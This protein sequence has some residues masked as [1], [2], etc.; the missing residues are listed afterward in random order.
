M[1]HLYTC[2]THCNQTLE[3][4]N[5]I[6]VRLSC[7]TATTLILLSVYLTTVNIFHLL[8]CT[9]HWFSPYNVDI[10]I[11][12]APINPPFLH[13]MLSIVV[14]LLLR[15]SRKCKSHVFVDLTRSGPLHR[16]LV[17]D[18]TGLVVSVKIP[19]CLLTTFGRHLI[20]CFPTF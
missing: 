4:L 18:E 9:Q 2:S 11:E 3:P 1:Y 14:T 8:Y 15:K 6:R 17:S 19:F 7:H 13:L 16:F 12:W 20:Q 5:L 10:L